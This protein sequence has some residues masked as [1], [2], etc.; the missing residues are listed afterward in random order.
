MD[1]NKGGN[2]YIA[3]KTTSFTPSRDANWI[4]D[5]NALADETQLSRN[6]LTSQLITLGLQVKRNANSSIQQAT[7]PSKKNENQPGVFISSEKLTAEQI[8]LLNT[9]HY[10]KILEEFTL[11]LL[12]AQQQATSQVIQEYGHKNQ[13]ESIIT[14]DEIASTTPSVNEVETKIDEE[15]FV[16]KQKPKAAN[17]N[18]A[19]RFLQSI[20]DN[21]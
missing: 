7:V 13:V 10:Q 6:K 20:K 4:E 21:G 15:S 11:R 1:T 3:G 16:E 9:N 8:E 5:F 2:Y 14:N 12:N 18:N 17:L 19:M